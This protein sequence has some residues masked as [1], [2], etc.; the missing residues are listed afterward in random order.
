[1][2]QSA[3]QLNDE[4]VL[5]AARAMAGFVNGKARPS[6]RP[7]SELSEKRIGTGEGRLG[8]SRHC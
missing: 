5:A 3:A 8:V 6:L 1:M 2:S 4:T 7:A